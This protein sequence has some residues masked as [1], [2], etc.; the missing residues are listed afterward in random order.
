MSADR[1]LLYASQVHNV[2]STLLS[3]RRVVSR[4]KSKP[5]K[6]VEAGHSLQDVSI[7][8]P[9][10]VDGVKASN[11]TGNAHSS[12]T[13]SSKNNPLGNISMSPYQ[14]QS[15]VSNISVTKSTTSP[16]S[17]KANLTQYTISKGPTTLPC[18]LRSNSSG[19]SKTVN[20]SKQMLFDLF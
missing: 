7:I 15:T 10:S 2:S 19:V 14:M 9:D 6:L 11:H 12:N 3:P 4:T 18:I 16:H 20:V 1:H 5:P 13:N 8:N 17:S